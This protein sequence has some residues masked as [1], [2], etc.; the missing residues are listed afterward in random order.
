MLGRGYRAFLFL[1]VM[2]GEER[3]GTER[4]D[5][6]IA[7]VQTETPVIFSAYV[8]LSGPFP[9]PPPHAA[10]RKGPFH[11]FGVI[12]VKFLGKIGVPVKR[13]G[14]IG[15]GRRVI[16]WVGVLRCFAVRV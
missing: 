3:V 5:V 10:Q 14:W 15:F 4:G 16:V 12:L 9:I 1:A 6:F 13:V 11:F 2:R 7:E 8:S